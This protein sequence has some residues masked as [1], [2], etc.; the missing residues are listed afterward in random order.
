MSNRVICGVFRAV[1][2]LNTPQIAGRAAVAVLAVALLT[3]CAAPQH[4]EPV[5]PAATSPQ[6]VD[7]ERSA[8]EPWLGEWTGEVNQFGLDQPYTVNLNLDHDGRT[9]VGTTEYPDLD[10]DGTL[11][12]AELDDRVLAVVET[13]VQAD[14]CMTPVD[15]ELTLQP[16]EIHYRFDE[17]GGGDGVLR[18]P[19]GSEV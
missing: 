8:V 3:Q 12:D 14:S 17:G 13:I 7:I 9:V 6:A 10:C 11:G 15:L 2:A 19:P 1:S 5:A 4:P 18:R 16:N